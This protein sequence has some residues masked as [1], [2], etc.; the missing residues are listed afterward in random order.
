[1]LKAFS[2]IALGTFYR[3]IPHPW[4]A[5]PMGALCLYSG[6]G[7]SRRWAWIVPLAV[8]GLSDWVL[9]YGTGRPFLSFSRWMI[10]ATFAATTLIGPLANRPKIGTWLLPGMSLAASCLFFVTS[11]FGAWVT[12]ESTYPLTFSGLMSCYVAAIP[13]FDKTVI[14]DLVGTAVLFG[15]G[16]I[17]VRA[18][19]LVLSPRTALATGN[20]ES[21]DGP[22]F[23]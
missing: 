4:N 10:Y 1:M 22:D 23:N 6:A 12:Q 16:A 19:H 13:F 9:D 17:L 15:A 18:R 8:M 5:V 3:L 7:I 14:A 11:N 20:G 21:I 2:L